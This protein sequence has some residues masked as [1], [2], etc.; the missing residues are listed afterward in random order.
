[1][2]FTRGRKHG[3]SVLRSGHLSSGAA[4][5]DSLLD[6]EGVDRIEV[7][8]ISFDPGAHIR[9]HSHSKGQIL[10]IEHGEGVIATRA[11]EV[12]VLQAADLIYSPP[13]EE[14][15]HGATPNSYLA[16]LNISMGDT[17]WLEPVT[18]EEYAH[19]CEHGVPG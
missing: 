12:R 8:T 14:H 4:W 7:S 13:G 9:W 10:R 16:Q 5:R 3:T 19:A 15:W 2:D 6:V 11:G 1:M 18:G 17:E